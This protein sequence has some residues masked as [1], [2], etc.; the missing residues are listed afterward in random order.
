MHSNYSTRAQGTIEYLVII[1]VV[2][3]IALVVVSLL[4]GMTGQS[5]GV[6]QNS[7]KISTMTSAIA[8]IDSESTKDGNI[9]LSFR[10]N[11]GETLTIKEI[12][13]AGKTLSNINETV[14]QGSNSNIVIDSAKVCTPGQ[15][16][17]SDI[18]AKYTTSSGLEKTEIIND[19][20]IKCSDFNAPEGVQAPL[21]STPAV[22]SQNPAVTLSSPHDTTQYNING[23]KV[24]FSFNASD[25][26]AIQNCT[27]IVGGTDRNT[28][29]SVANG[30]NSIDYNLATIG[31][32][33]YAWDVNCVDSSGNSAKKSNPESDW[34]ISYLGLLT[35]RFSGN[36][37]TLTD[38]PVIAPLPKKPGMRNDY[39]DLRFN[40]AG[41]DLNYWMQ[42]SNASFATFWI[43][44][45]TLVASANTDMNVFYG[46]PS[47]TISN[48][49]ENRVFYFYDEF[50][51]TTLDTN[52]WVL[53]TGSGFCGTA[54]FGD[55]NVTLN[56]NVA[57]SP[58]W[59][60]E[61]RTKEL[62]IPTS[63]M[64]YRV[65][66]QVNIPS[67][68]NVAIAFLNT[69]TVLTGTN[70][71]GPTML[72]SFTSCRSG[73]PSPC[74]TQSFNM[75]P[76][77]LT[78]QGVS[79]WNKSWILETRLFSNY[80]KYNLNQIGGAGYGNSWS[81][82]IGGTWS[83]SLMLAIYVSDGTAYSTGTTSFNYFRV[84][85]YALSDAN[86][87]SIIAQ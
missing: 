40:I 87:V 66:T 27:L 70:P 13:V 35:L 33:E 18:I 86:N 50:N 84:A 10:N 20:Q 57:T 26:S 51:A 64:G 58:N 67:T 54:T 44:V 4:T 22:D 80:G 60:T 53:M 82:G 9:F 46:N 56:K 12:S 21:G 61:L 68:Q 76:P 8:V 31:M 49:D 41:T 85:K 79:Q 42:D 32:G 24:T 36:T 72:A 25:N 39:N 15:T 55:G 23:G 34:N 19:A 52:K 77:N 3:V 16:I 43:K 73:N 69:Y 29:T 71:P 2:V 78:Y 62:P 47:T 6:S 83:N 7:S 81:G 17:T 37:S 1:A 65:Y 28:I 11:T 74:A 48:G 59:T 14:V 45:P 38:Y 30:A 75:N 5:I 63:T